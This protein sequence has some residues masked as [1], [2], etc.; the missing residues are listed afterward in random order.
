VAIGPGAHPASAWYQAD[1]GATYVLNAD[2][3]GTPEQLTRNN[4]E[5]R[6]LAWSPDSARIV[7]S[8]RIGGGTADFEICVMN[9]DGSDVQQLTSNT[10]P[11]LSPTFSPD[12]Q[13][14]VFQRLVSGQGFQLFTMNAALN[15]DGTLPTP[16]KLTSPPGINLIAH[17]GELRVKG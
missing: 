1:P 6:A 14:I 12:G 10:V 15:P 2:G 17:W 9:A 8:C 4:E 5:E 16:T 11:D 7:Y 3:S 13:Q